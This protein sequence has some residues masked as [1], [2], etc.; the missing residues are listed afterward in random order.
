VGA[1]KGVKL[2]IY[3]TGFYIIKTKEESLKRNLV[4]Q[5]WIWIHCY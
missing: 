3:A 2:D 4:Y 1:V 5:N